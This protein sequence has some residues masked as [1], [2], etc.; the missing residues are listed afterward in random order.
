MQLGVTVTVVGG[1]GV[2]STI[3]GVRVGVGVLVLRPV[4]LLL[5]AGVAVCLGLSVPV[6]DR[7]GE[8]VVAFM[9]ST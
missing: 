8:A 7:L 1:L 3:E 2:S 5:L 9:C 4:V 6:G